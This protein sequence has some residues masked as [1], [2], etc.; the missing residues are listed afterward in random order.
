[1][2]TSQLLPPSM[3]GDS[4]LL[5]TIDGVDAALSTLLTYRLQLTA[6]LDHRGLAKELGARDTVEFL[7]LRHHRNAREI[8]R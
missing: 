2:E 1:M 6:D 5:S 3:L 7:E 4:A 8:R